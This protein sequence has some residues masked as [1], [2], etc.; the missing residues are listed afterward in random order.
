M[1]SKL[2]TKSQN[3]II[4]LFETVWKLLV[5]HTDFSS[6]QPLLEALLS[7]NLVSHLD[8]EDYGDETELQDLYKSYRES[9]YMMNVNSELLPMVI[10]LQHFKT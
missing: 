10:A 2:S 1:G 6:S 3:G 4:L 7:A 9:F 8:S 5:K